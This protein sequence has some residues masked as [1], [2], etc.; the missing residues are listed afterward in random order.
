MLFISR[1][2]QHKY[3]DKRR[4]NATKS[5]LQSAGAGAG[6]N[7]KTTQ[8]T[9][10]T[11]AAGRASKSATAAASGTVS[12]SS[13][14]DSDDPYTTRQFSKRTI[15][16]NWDKYDG[17]AATTMDKS[18]FAGV[19]DV[20]DDHNGQMSAA[21]FGQLLRAPAAEG[22]HFRFN[23]EKSWDSAGDAAA[24]DLFGGTG[25]NGAAESDGGEQFFQM[26]ISRLERILMER[27]FCER[28]QYDEAV[29]TVNELTRMAK[30]VT[31]ETAQR[32][33]GLQ[34]R[35]KKVQSLAG[36]KIEEDSRRNKANLLC[37]EMVKPK[38]QQEQTTTMGPN[39]TINDYETPGNSVG[40]DEAANSA[41]EA[42]LSATHIQIPKT[43][44]NAQCA[45]PSVAPTP[46]GSAAPI[47]VDDLQQWLDEIL[48]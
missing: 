26:N 32:V 24:G 6:H 22:V 5:Q 11:A 19:G 20:D 25:A 46:I 30:E 4:N 28:Q 3:K 39:Q 9:A 35:L 38:Q 44:E 14:S 40:S 27:P 45:Q 7:Q 48:D 42:L 34:A 8:P 10:R 12:T 37:E 29:F 17:G 18:A 33:D 31:Q 2:Q 43:T 21:D 16:K 47:V 23:S 13:S 41:L 15:V 1:N 36:S